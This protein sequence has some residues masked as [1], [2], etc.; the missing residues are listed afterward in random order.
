MANY[1]MIIGKSGS[2]KSH[3]MKGLNP[4]RTL[5]VNV[6]GKQFPFQNKFK[7]IL[8]TKNVEIIKDQ[9]R[10][11]PSN[12]KTV[13]IDDFGYVMTDMFMKGHGGGD[14]FKLYNS[15]G[16][17]VYSFFN[18]LQDELPDD[19]TVYVVMHE[20]ES[21]TG[22]IKPRTIGK[23]LDQKVCLEGMV[24]VCLRAVTTRDGRHVF[25][26]QSDG[27]DVAKSPEGM[28]DGDEIPNDLAAVDA[29][30]REFWGIKDLPP[31]PTNDKAPT[32]PTNQGKATVTVTSKVPAPGSNP[33]A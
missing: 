3:A 18:F 30:I 24:T 23:L 4:D 1:F 25:R 6:C 32:A 2:G 13:V 10:K 21:D 11:M 27:Y 7:Y 28:F 5:V 26:V 8:K 14:Q 22:S 19:V 33:A 15:I 12:V 17:T 20:E 29:R 31:K 9:L 16:D